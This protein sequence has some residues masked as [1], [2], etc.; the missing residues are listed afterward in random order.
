MNNGIL[1]VD[2]DDAHR[3]MLRTMLRSWGYTVDEAADGDEAVDTLGH[4]A[5]G[6]Y[7]I[8]LM[9]IQMPRMNGYDATRA[10]RAMKRPYCRKVPIIAMTAN[11]FA[12]DIQTSLA[13]GM[14]GH[15][16]K[17]INLSVLTETLKKWID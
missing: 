12:E 17:P 6:Y 11:A 1:V 13:V 15:L 7:D 5:E 8:V 4:C 3:G 16:A 14:N 10:I 9:D 2:D